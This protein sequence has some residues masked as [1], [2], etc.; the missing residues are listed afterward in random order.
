M[1]YGLQSRPATAARRQRG[2]AM[3]IALVMLLVLTVLGTATA[4]L[5]LLEERMTGNTQDNRVAFQAAEA[6]LR[7]G[8]DLLEEPVI[9]DFDGTGAL[10]QPAAPDEE[11]LWRSLDFAS[12][13]DASQY[14]GFADADG[15]LAR[16]GASWFIEELPRVPTSGVS[17]AADTPVD[18][19]RFYRV[20]AR[21]V[22]IAGAAAVTL[23]TTY[24]R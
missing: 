8:E 13:G 2:A 1:I 3:V 7:D 4:R 17:L 15:S 20:T 5:T 16:A 23:Q 14:G 6:A 21:G 10:Y 11:P 9:P 12:A 22:G 19:A 24:R 18:D